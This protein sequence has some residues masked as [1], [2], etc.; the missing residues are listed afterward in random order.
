MKR[1]A[2]GAIYRKSLQNRWCLRL[3]TNHPDGDK[4]DGIITHIKR[5]FIVLRQADNFEFDGIVVL[6]KRVVS[7]YR[8]DK[9][10][11]CFN[12]ILRLNGQLDRCNQPEWL[13]ECRSLPELFRQLKARDIWPGVEIVFNEGK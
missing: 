7:G 11:R 4:Y 9:F 2:L 6:P 12:A 3:K 5:R 13:E 1:L 8:D 10:E